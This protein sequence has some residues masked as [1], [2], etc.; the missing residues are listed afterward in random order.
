MR[1]LLELRQLGVGPQLHDVSLRLAAGECVGLIGPNGAGKTTL[2]RAALGLVRHR[3]SSSLTAMQPGARARHAG[4]LPQTRSVAWPVTVRD[5]VALGRMPWRAGGDP[6][7]AVATA[8]AQVGLVALAGRE[9]TTLSGGELARA[10]LA[11]VLVQDTP[12][13]LAD[14]PVAG[15]DPAQQIAVLRL[16][17]GLAG[18]GR[19]VLVSLHDLSLAARFCTRIIVLDRGHLVADGAPQAVLTP[20]LLARVFGLQ[21]QWFD[22]KAGPALHLEEA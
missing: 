3:G 12:L 8:L 6:G 7:P 2:M 15:L 4:F 22:T 11:R 17:R 13:V 18:Q 21:A 19:G 10:L 1:P 5:L 14:E 20:D 9:A 16:L